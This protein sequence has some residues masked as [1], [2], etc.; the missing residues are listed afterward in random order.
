MHTL[1]SRTPE[2]EVWIPTPPHGPD[3]ARTARPQRDHSASSWVLRIKVVVPIQR[4]CISACAVARLVQ[5][6]RL[7]NLA[8]LSQN[9]PRVSLAAVR[10]FS[11]GAPFTRRGVNKHVRGTLCTMQIVPSSPRCHSSWPSPLLVALGPLL[12]ALSRGAAAALD[13]DVCIPRAS[14]CLLMSATPRCFVSKSAGLSTPATFWTVRSPLRILSCTHKNCTLRC[15]SF[16]SPCRWEIASAALAS[17]YILASTFMPRS[18]ATDIRPSET[19]APFV[20]LKSSASALDI[21]TVACVDDHD[22]IKCEPSRTTPPEV[23]RQVL[24][25]PAQSESTDVSRRVCSRCQKNVC[26]AL[27]APT[28]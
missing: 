10:D 19:A 21:A 11:G 18:L 26:T 14:T 27:G 24:V 28:R 3:G 22:F 25:Q 15:R 1:V 4:R 23:L 16:P 17:E 7:R 20:R 6:S 9:V 2:R 5:L 13:L 12:V 8:P